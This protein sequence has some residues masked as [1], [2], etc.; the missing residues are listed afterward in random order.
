MAK[1]REGHSAEH[2][3]EEREVSERKSMEQG[4]EMGTGFKVHES[5]DFCLNTMD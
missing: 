5:G 1:E 4:Q 3:N 2:V